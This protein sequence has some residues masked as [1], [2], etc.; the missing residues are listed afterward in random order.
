MDAL[1]KSKRDVVDEGLLEELREIV[2]APDNFSHL[3]EDDEPAND[4]DPRQQVMKE[5]SCDQIRTLVKSMRMEILLIFS[6]KTNSRRHS[7]FRDGGDEKTKRRLGDLPPVEFFTK[8]QANAITQV[9]LG[10]FK[11]ESKYF[12]YVFKVLLP[13]TMCLLYANTQK[14]SYEEAEKILNLDWSDMDV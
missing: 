12:N 5:Y 8:D 1:I 4:D 10:F 6:G 11:Y 3:S 7:V 9:L 2:D 13:E 14:M